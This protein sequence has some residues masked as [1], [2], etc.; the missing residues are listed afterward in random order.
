MFCS[1][2]GK[3]IPEVSIFCMFCGSNIAAPQQKTAPLAK[4][5]SNKI[6]NIIDTLGFYFV[7]PI[8]KKEGN[9]K[10]ALSYAQEALYLMPNNTQINQ[11]VNSF[12]VSSTPTVSDTTK[13]IKNIKTTT[14]D[15]KIQ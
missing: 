4:I 6:P 3:A 8:L 7:G 5:F 13:D 15:K 12:N 14:K 2:C 1:S 9:N 10:D 11:Y